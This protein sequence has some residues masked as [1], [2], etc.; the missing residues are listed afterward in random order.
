MPVACASLA[1]RPWEESATHWPV[2][3]MGRLIKQALMAYGNPEPS[4]QEFFWIS[5]CWAYGE[6][7]GF[8][9]PIR[10]YTEA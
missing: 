2:L 1:S 4:N 9:S 3:R 10:R 5:A 8:S 7:N 6:S